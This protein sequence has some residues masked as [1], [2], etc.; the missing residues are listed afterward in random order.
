MIVDADCDWDLEDL[1]M[2]LQTAQT[3]EEADPE[4]ARQLRAQAAMVKEKLR[5]TNDL[6]EPYDPSA[7][8]ARVLRFY[9][10]G[11]TVEDLDQMRYQRFF[12]LV[13]E[14]ELI[15]EE[16]RKEYDKARHNQGNTM[17][18]SA[19]INDMQQPEEYTGETIRLI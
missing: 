15:A 7:L 3:I 9:Q 6:R 13:R 17:D 4:A 10:G 19:A 2:A 12:G 16:E 18:A 8:Q 14:A 5:G 11:I 1:D